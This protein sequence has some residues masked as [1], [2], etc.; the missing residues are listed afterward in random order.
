MKAER[1]E[2]AVEIFTELKNYDEAKRY[3]KYLKHQG[4]LHRLLKDQAEWVNETG[5]WRMAADLFIKGRDFA[6]AIEIYKVNGDME[7]LIE[8]CRTLDKSQNLKE[9]ELCI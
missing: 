7:S 2:R 9:I 6:K 1:P 5:D 4:N 3:S 8:L